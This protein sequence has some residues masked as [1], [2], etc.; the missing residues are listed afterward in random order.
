MNEAEDF[1]VRF[2]EWVEDPAAGGRVRGGGINHGSSDGKEED[3]GFR[4]DVGG[5]YAGTSDWWDKRREEPGR[6]T[7]GFLILESE[8]CKLY[9][10]SDR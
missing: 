5:V 9:S 3:I 8:P 7:V 1:R 6:T 2:R 10:P 4:Q